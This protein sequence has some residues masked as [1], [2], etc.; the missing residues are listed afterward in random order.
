MRDFFYG[1][2]A[3]PE[4]TFFHLSLSRSRYFKTNVII[5]GRQQSQ[6]DIPYAIGAGVCV[7]S[8]AN[9]GHRNVVSHT[10]HE[11]CKIAIFFVIILEWKTRARIRV[12]ELREREMGN[13]GI[14]V[15]AP[16]TTDRDCHCIKMNL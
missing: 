1:I 7:Y 11:A 8:H 9:V 6:Y 12:S 5:A 13:S 4:L 2:R 3:Y 16:P 10:S 14:N 15:R